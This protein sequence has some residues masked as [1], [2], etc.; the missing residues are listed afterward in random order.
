MSPSV[1]P[2]LKLI[3]SSQV[4]YNEFHENELR[5]RLIIV[6]MEWQMYIRQYQR[7][8]IVKVSDW[9]MFFLHCVA[10]IFINR[11]NRIALRSCLTDGF[12]IK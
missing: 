6:H 10:G 9:T 12:L 1:N 4:V 7:F 11:T 5:D 2:K 3:Y 8:I